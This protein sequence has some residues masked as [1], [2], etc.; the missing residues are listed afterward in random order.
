MKYLAILPL[1]VIMC[2]CTKNIAPTSTNESGILINGILPPLS[3]AEKWEYKGIVE[4]TFPINNNINSITLSGG[5]FVSDKISK[6][7]YYETKI[8]QG[9][10]WYSIGAAMRG[11]ASEEIYYNWENNRYLILSEIWD[12]DNNL[13][14]HTLWFSIEPSN[15]PTP[16]KSP[17]IE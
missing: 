11:G 4:M 5:L 15:I 1:F 3:P 17:T 7:S 2:S 9:K 6:D 8:M 10:G 12:Y 16:I 14:F 13:S